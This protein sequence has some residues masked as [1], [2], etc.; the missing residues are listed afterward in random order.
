ML[1]SVVFAYALVGTPGAFIIM[2]KEN[3]YC[4]Q[5]CYVNLSQRQ[6]VVST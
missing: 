2:A 1:G 3:G 6:A 5:H 4:V